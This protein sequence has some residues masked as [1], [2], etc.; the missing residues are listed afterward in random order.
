MERESG[1]LGPR[2]GQQKQELEL[3]LEPEREEIGPGQELVGET[4]KKARAVSC[5]RRR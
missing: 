5:L 2:S 3:E 1:R 4:E